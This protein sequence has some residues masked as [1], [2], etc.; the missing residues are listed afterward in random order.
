MKTSKTLSYLV[1]GALLTLSATALLAQGAGKGRGYAAP[2][3]TAEARAA[4]QA[5]CPK[6]G[7]QCPAV[8]PKTGTATQGQA[9]G[10]GQCNGTGQGKGKGLRD[11]T[12]PRGANRT[13]PK[14]APA[15]AQTK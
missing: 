6:N 2:A 13:C 4:R 9:C 7:T 14:T 1:A 5:A 15:P 3:Q 12:G 8:C 11:G 10:Q